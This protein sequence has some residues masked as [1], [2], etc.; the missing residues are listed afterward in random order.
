MGR[1]SWQEAFEQ[2]FYE[3]LP[4]GSLCIHHLLQDA[5]VPFLNPLNRQEQNNLGCFL[6]WER[7]E[8]K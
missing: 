8:T 7:N 6:T 5:S 4:T 3:K 2:I 1:F